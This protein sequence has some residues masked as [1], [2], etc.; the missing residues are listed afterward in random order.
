MH[1]GKSSSGWCFAL[2]V[3]PTK[4][5]IDLKDW[6]TIWSGGHIVSE[7]GDRLSYDDMMDC[8]TK[9]KS[10]RAVDDNYITMLNDC[11]LGRVRKYASVAEY[12]EANE[13][14]PGPNNLMRHRLSDRCIL[15]GEGTWDCIIGEF[16]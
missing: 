12:Y 5:I 13:A 4:G 11:P 10:E 9:R 7:Y 1:I 2:H 16:S 14:E 8:I 6:Q 3:Y 15:H